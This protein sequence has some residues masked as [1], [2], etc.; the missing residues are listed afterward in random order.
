MT[1]YQ[2]LLEA[3]EAYRTARDNSERYHG[4]GTKATEVYSDAYANGYHDVRTE[5]FEVYHD[6]YL[7]YANEYDLIANPTSSQKEE[8]DD[9]L[10][11]WEA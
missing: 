11:Q 8:Y 1:K 10:R 9:A 7:A 2:A 5:A 6:A 4:V 3:R